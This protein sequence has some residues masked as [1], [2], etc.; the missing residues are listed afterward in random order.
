[1]SWAAVV[2]F[3]MITRER[4]FAGNGIATTM[5][6]IAHEPLPSPD[7]VQRRDRSGSLGRPRLRFREGPG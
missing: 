7:P 3:E 1:M 5:Y 2:F 6:R 4:P